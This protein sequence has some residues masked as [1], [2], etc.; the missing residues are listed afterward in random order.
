MIKKKSPNEQV[1]ARIFTFQLELEIELVV[2]YLLQSSYNL[3]VIVFKLAHESVN[4]TY[5]A[6]S[7]IVLTEGY[8][9]ERFID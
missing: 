2:V 3:C 7:K 6:Y 1:S 8:Q 4:R 5:A 9:M